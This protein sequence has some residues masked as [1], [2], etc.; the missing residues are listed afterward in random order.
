[1]PI[2]IPRVSD[3]TVARH[4]GDGGRSFEAL[5]LA[6]RDF[7]SGADC[8]RGA[9]RGV[10]RSRDGRTVLCLGFAI[11]LSQCIESDSHEGCLQQ[12]RKSSAGSCCE[13][14]RDRN[15]TGEQFS[16]NSLADALSRGAYLAQQGAITARPPCPTQKT[17]TAL[18]ARAIESSEQIAWQVSQERARVFTFEGWANPAFSAG[19]WS[20]VLGVANE[21][22]G[23]GHRAP[24]AV[25]VGDDAR[26]LTR[27][28]RPTPALFA[29]TAAGASLG[30]APLSRHANLYRQASSPPYATRERSRPRLHTLSRSR[31]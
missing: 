3:T 5:L 11:L 24:L 1:M 16:A 28:I 23:I 27:F 22:C 19:E 17:A 20:A 7:G 15:Y 31:G 29:S 25:D 26:H 6:T 8:S 2:L 21:C 18:S 12:G 13:G 14:G 30:C 9:S 4:S 10:S